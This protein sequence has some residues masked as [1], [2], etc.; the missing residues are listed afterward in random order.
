MWI[1]WIRVIQF[2]QDRETHTSKIYPETHTHT[3]EGGGFVWCHT[4]WGFGRTARGITAEVIRTI[5]WLG[6]ARPEVGG[7]R[8]K[9][10]YRTSPWWVFESRFPP[11]LL[12]KPWLNLMEVTCVTDACINY[13]V[14]FFRLN[15]W[16][17]CSL[18]WKHV[19]IYFGKFQSMQK[20]LP[21]AVLSCCK[22]VIL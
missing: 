16:L 3:R 13:M 10:F 12:H 8:G 15:I 14:D 11:H 20:R 4:V 2:M 22:L 6:R 21:H 9:P 1:N 7:K 18:A 17:F 5:N 19:H